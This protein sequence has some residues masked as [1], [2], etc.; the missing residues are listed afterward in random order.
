[1][2]KRLFWLVLGAGF[3]FGMAF[4]LSRF[5]RQ[6]IERYSPER[7]STDLGEALSRFGADLRAAVSE[8]REAMRERE[9]SLRDEVES[10]RRPAPQD[11]N[12]TPVR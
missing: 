3:G 12:G 5:V 6:T 7:V 11:D 2:F 10:P 4:W 8:G 1:M 9:V